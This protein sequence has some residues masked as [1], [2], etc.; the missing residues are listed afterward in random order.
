MDNRLPAFSYTEIAQTFNAACAAA[1]ASCIHFAAAEGDA[2][3]DPDRPSCRLNFRLASWHTSSRT[4]S[5]AVGRSTR[6]FSRATKACIRRRSAAR[7]SAASAAVT[8]SSRCTTLEKL[9]PA[10]L[11][12]TT[13]PIA[14]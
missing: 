12:Y 5:A 8:R 2:E 11:S 4:Y 13:K 7:F 10:T 9:A 6:L 3:G 1:P 14:Q